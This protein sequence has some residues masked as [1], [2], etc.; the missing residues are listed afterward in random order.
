MVRKRKYLLSLKDLNLMDTIPDLI[1]SGVTS[2]KIEGRYKRTDYVKNITAAY[3]QAI[4]HFIS[5]HPGYCRSSSGV[6]E[7]TFSPDPARTFNRGYTRYFVS[8]KREKKASIDTQKSIGQ[9][10]GVIGTVGKDHFTVDCHELN[11][12]DGICFFTRKS[13]LAGFRIDRIDKGKIYPNK[14]KD[15]EAGIRLYRNHD[16]VFIQTLKKSSARR[17]IAVSMVF[18]QEDALVRLTVRDEDGNEATSSREAPFDPPRNLSRVLEQIRTHLSG[19]G[20]TPYHAAELTICPEEPGFL[21]AGTLNGVRRD[22]LELL[23]RVRREKC[24]LERIQ[25]VRNNAPYPEKKAGL[26]RQCPE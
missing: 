20:N 2:F 10:V 7:L 15:L 6:S 4:D 3:R 26:S 18:T 22:A 17:R 19:T 8:G 5:V 9:Y 23:T 25:L 24:P 14:M 1:A 12:G 21:P 13:D 11:N 16:T